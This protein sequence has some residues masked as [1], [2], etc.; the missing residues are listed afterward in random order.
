MELRVLLLP[1][2]SLFLYL[3]ASASSFIE[4]SVLAVIGLAL[5]NLTGRKLKY[6]QLWRMAAYSETLPTVFF[7]IMAAVKT[8]C[9]K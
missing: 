7:T 8:I 4:I 5:K 6:G 3:F 9:S 2:I 1:V